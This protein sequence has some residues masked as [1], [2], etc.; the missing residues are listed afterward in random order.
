M[1]I[2]LSELKRPFKIEID[3]GKREIQVIKTQQNL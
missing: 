3:S 1:Q 2:K